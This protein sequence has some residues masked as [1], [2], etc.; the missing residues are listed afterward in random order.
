MIDSKKK[1]RVQGSPWLALLVALP[2]EARGILKAG[3]WQ[4]VPA[5]ASLA[6][7]RGCVDGVEAIVAVSG[8]GRARAEATAREVIEEHRPDA[9]VSLGFAGGLAEGD[10]A[11][12]LVVAERLMSVEV[13]HGETG[14]P[15]V[16]DSLASD[17]ELVQQA[18]E[19]LA[20]Q[21]LSHGSGS[22]LTASKIVS[23]PHEK[24]ALGRLTQAIAVE[25]E[26][27][28]IG[29]VCRERNVP[30]L[31]VRA[32]VDTAERQLPGFVAEFAFGA[33][34]KS[35]WRQ[36][37]PVMFHPWWIPGLFRLGKAAS[38]ARGALTTF[39]VAFMASRTQEAVAVE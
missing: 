19:V 39:A 4:R 23:E 17:Q 26:S 7:Y 30:F 5:S 31:A 16:S 11:G 38:R 14:T 32:I 13:A 1:R 27:F 6:T 35:R 25:Q 9:V 20:S 28:W 15:H 22:C 36:A 33:G 18:L 37:L 10:A 3:N 8:V 21:G 34:T 2:E 24:V 29:H 12:D